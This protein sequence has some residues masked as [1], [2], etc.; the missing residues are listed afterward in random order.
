MTERL[1][2]LDSYAKTYEAAIVGRTGGC[3]RAEARG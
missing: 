2:Q 3:P 1:F